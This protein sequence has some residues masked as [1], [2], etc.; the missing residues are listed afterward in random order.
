M[1]QFT[2]FVAIE[3]REKVW[4]NLPV[5]VLSFDT[6]WQD[7][8]FDQSKGPSIAELVDKEN[9]DTLQYMGWEIDQSKDLPKVSCVYNLI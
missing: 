3:K 2:S 9:V 4:T 7:E 8:K 1:S 5:T 6:C